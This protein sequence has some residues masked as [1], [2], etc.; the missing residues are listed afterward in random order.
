MYNQREQHKNLGNE[1]KESDSD[2]SCSYI[3]ILIFIFIMLIMNL[4][5]LVILGKLIAR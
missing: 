2:E 1:K 4:F 5:E 3:F